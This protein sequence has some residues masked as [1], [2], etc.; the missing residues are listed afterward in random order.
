[1][2]IKFLQDCTAPQEVYKTLCECCGP[3][4]YGSEDTF[5]GVNE[6]LDPDGNYTNNKIDLSGLKFGVHY[7]I[8]EYP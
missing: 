5:F 2:K 8:I 4:K 1:M 3:E 6:E 7:T